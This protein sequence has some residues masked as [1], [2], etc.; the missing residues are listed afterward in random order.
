MNEIDLTKTPL[1][2]LD[3]SK[4]DYNKSY[5][6]TEFFNKKISTIEH[7]YDDKFDIVDTANEGHHFYKNG[8]WV[9]GIGK[10]LHLFYKEEKGCGNCQYIC[11]L[12]YNDPCCKCDTIN[13]PFWQPKEVKERPAGEWKQ[14]N[15]HP[16]I[17]E[18]QDLGDKVKILKIEGVMSADE[19]EEHAGRDVLLKY[20]NV[21]PS[22]MKTII[23]EN[24]VV[25]CGNSNV[26]NRYPRTL[27][28]GEEKDKNAFFDAIENMKLSAKRLAE[29]IKEFK[30]TEI[31]RIVI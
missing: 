14:V 9:H 21:A 4:I 2:E 28:I 5:V 27:Y 15:S 29:L 16:I 3:L 1:S 23:H 7:Y 10:T 26:G 24:V 12:P 13:H 17:I 8:R 31:K 25:V 30:K 11:T 18:Y 19:I 22:M 6:E 20:A